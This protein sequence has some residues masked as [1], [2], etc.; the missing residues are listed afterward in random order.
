GENQKLDFKFCISDS[1]KIARSLVAFANTDG[2]KLLIGVKDNGKIAG[3]KTD[4]EIYMIQAAAQ[5]YCKPQIDFECKQWIEDSKLVLEISVSKGDKKPYYALD[6]NDNWKVFIRVDDQN[7]I[8]NRVLLKVWQREKRK[9]GIYLKYTDK[10]KNLLNYLEQNNS[11][12]FSKYCRLAHISKNKAEK[13][14]VN[15]ITLNIIDI[16]FTE[17]QTYYKLKGT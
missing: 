4:E 14:L 9:S 11:I 17:K 16:V 6:N 2:G 12:T 5:M 8:A 15:F 7:L 1:K 10:E 3:V 13:I